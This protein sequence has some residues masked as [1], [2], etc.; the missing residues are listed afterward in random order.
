MLLATCS[1][2]QAKRLY[3]ESHY[4]KY[5]ANLVGGE[6]EVVLGD[7]TRCDIVTA[8]HVIEVDLMT[9]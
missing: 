8:T 1:L 2:L 7:K 6:S 4:Q 3:P 5:Y 9:A